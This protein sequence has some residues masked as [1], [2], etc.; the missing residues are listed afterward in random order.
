M[1]SSDWSSD[2]CS[3]DL[4]L[5]HSV[6]QS[7]GGADR[8]AAIGNGA[9]RTSLPHHRQR[10]RPGEWPAREIDRKSVVSGK[11]VSVRVD[12]RGRR[13]LNKQSQKPTSEP[14]PQR[15]SRTT[16]NTPKGASLMV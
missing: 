13:I 16:N 5:G 15:T 2:V 6:E 10:A 11:S 7:R 8:I 14:N 12:L 1:G 4:T 9:D 3:S